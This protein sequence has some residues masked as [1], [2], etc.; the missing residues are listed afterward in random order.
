[1]PGAWQ[2]AR[3]HY[4]EMNT[5]IIPSKAIVNEGPND[6]L[7]TK[8]LTFNEAIWALEWVIAHLDFAHNQEHIIENVGDTRVFT[9]I[10][11]G[12]KFYRIVISPTFKGGQWMFSERLIMAY[13]TENKA[14]LQS[15]KSAVLKL[16]EWQRELYTELPNFTEQAQLIIKLIRKQWNVLVKSHAYSG[17]NRSQILA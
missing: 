8:A 9:F 11:D 4:K 5:N 3:H 1:M 15:F 13:D 10:Q 14:R 12:W 6:D 7:P 2:P 16:P 17:P